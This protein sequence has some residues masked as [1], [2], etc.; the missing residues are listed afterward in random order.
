MNRW[1]VKT[2]H[3]FFYRQSRK[4]LITDIQEG[5]LLNMCIWSADNISLVCEMLDFIIDMSHGLCVGFDPR[6]I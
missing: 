2:R 6:K 3:F 1:L 4:P 5:M